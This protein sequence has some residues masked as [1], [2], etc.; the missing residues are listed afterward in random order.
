MLTGILHTY[1]IVQISLWILFHALGILKA[2]GKLKYAHISSVV[3]AIILPLVPALLPLIDGYSI[4]LSSFDVCFGRNVALTY[5]TLV[6]P[7][8]ILIAFATTILIAMF[9]KIV[10]V[11]EE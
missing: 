6:L 7:F 10:K 11:M 4:V 3:I 2:Q 5:F 1:L 8:S 9:W